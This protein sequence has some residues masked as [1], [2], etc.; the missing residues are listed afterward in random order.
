MQPA[1][2]ET[3]IT[4]V[5]V[6]DVAAGRSVPDQTVVVAGDR[7]TRTGARAGFKVP[8]GARIVDGT[9][10]FLIPGLWDMHGPPITLR[11]AIRAGQH[12]SS[13]RD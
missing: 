2:R 11:E 9:G 6:I 3:V 5:T 4:G 8:A 13:T 1:L 10:K 12:S 7:I